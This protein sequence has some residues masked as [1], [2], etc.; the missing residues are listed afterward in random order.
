MPVLKRCFHVMYGFVVK[1]FSFE[2]IT[3]NG[4]ILWKKHQWI[5][6]RKWLPGLGCQL[7]GWRSFRT[8]FY[9]N[10]IETKRNEYIFQCVTQKN[11]EKDF[12][13]LIRYDL[14]L[15]PQKRVTALDEIVFQTAQCTTFHLQPCCFRRAL[16]NLFCL[17]KSV[18]DADRR[19][20]LLINLIVRYFSR[21]VPNSLYLFK[22]C[23]KISI[24][25]YD[26]DMLHWC[27]LS[28]FFSVL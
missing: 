5:S 19:V 11:G 3:K 13:K 6:K 22:S 23:K 27:S 4:N 17:I 15:T 20:G 24:T 14:P 9:E 16:I 21:I 1:S 7:P 28:T 8:T 2:R 10:C 12:T 18:F 25:G 26:N